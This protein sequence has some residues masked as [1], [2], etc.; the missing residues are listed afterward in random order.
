MSALAARLQNTVP[1]GALADDELD[2]VLLWLSGRVHN[3]HPDLAA[4]LGPVE[5]QPELRWQV[6]QHLDEVLFVD[7]QLDSHSA[8]VHHSLDDATRRTRFRRLA[9]AF[10]TDR[11]NDPELI[12]WLTP[13]A[14]AIGLAYTA[15]RQGDRSTDG[16]VPSLSNIDDWLKDIEGRS[17]AELRPRTPPVW[18]RRLG[19]IQNLHIKLPA[20]LAVIILVPLFILLLLTPTPSPVAAPNPV[21]AQA[22]SSPRTVPMSA[23]KRTPMV[24]EQETGVQ[25]APMPTAEPEPDTEV[26][27]AVETESAA[28]EPE[29][30]I[31]AVQANPPAVEPL[32]AKAPDQPKLATTPELAAAPATLTET[33]VALKAEPESNEAEASEPAAPVEAP[34]PIQHNPMQVIERA[35]AAIEAAE[36]QALMTTLT[37]IPRE[38]QQRG[39]HWFRIS[40]G[41]LFQSTTRRHIEF[42]P[43]SVSG[44]S[45]RWQVMGQ[46]QLTVDF[47]DREPVSVSRITRYVVIKDDS[48]ELRIASIDY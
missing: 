5:A 47:K 11:Y 31:V 28:A 34:E 27:A 6:F 12:E 24:T 46:L 35:H 2:A 25:T 42:M 43:L 21:L 32:P 7:C 17:S 20:A 30:V 22:P 4:A 15:F 16:S 44:Q 39:Q 9:A 19:H 48:G 38:N 29:P 26:A 1:C 37:E 13:R 41:N 18:L 23:A 8:H 36:L 3:V 33:I 14:Q 40:Y 10:H 45:P